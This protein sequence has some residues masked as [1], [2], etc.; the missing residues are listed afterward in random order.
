[1]FLHARILVT[2]D[3]FLSKMSAYENQV[4][5]VADVRQLYKSVVIEFCKGFHQA[6]HIICKQ[7]N[8]LQNQIHAKLCVLQRCSSLG[9][10]WVWASQ[11]RPSWK[12]SDRSKGIS[13]S[14]ALCSLWCTRGW[15]LR[16]ASGVKGGLQGARPHFLEQDLEQSVRTV[17]KSARKFWMVQLFLVFKC[18]ELV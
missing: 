11:R 16:L 4:V 18:R 10:L 2:N 15:G 12:E 14:L 8:L 13:G 6:F 5:K 17:Q 7:E 1:M 3:R 9:Y